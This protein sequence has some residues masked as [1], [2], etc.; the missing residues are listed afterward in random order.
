[1]ADVKGRT[2]KL[3]VSTDDS[4]YYDIGG[5]KD[6]SFSA[7]RDTIDV[8]DNDSTGQEHLEGLPSASLSFTCN[9][10][11]A[12]TAFST[13]LTS[14]ENGTQIYYRY[15]PR[16]DTSTAKEYKFQ[17]TITSFEA[18]GATD[19]AVEMSVEVESTGSITYGTQT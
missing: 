2:A 12:D 7:S 5:A 14:N 6:I 9:Y 17:G 3:A 13:L 11:E 10:D 8:T 15:R 4:T 16:G 19:G 1:M 18:S